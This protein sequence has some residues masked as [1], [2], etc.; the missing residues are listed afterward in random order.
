MWSTIITVGLQIVGWI[1]QKNADNVEM[2]KQF[3]DFIEEQHENYL[4]SSA[5]RQ[6]AQ[7]RFL[8]IANKPFQESP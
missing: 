4:N 5:M 7:A 2:Q 1:L 8:E 3:Y 6:K